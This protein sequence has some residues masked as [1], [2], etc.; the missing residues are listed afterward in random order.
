MLRALAKHRADRYQTAEEMRDAFEE[1]LAG[2]ATAVFPALPV[3][4]V[5]VRHTR[6]P[7]PRG[8]RKE[9]PVPRLRIHRPLHAMVLLAAVACTYVITGSRAPARPPVGAPSLIGETTSEARANAQAVGVRI[10]P[11]RYRVCH[12]PGTPVGRVCEQT[13]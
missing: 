1:V 6:Q 2:R 3:P 4:P 5:T 8:P 11:I 7:L 12:R 13:P 9:R 10:Q